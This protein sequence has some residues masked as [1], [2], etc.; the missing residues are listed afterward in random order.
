MN[1][2]Y[3]I[4]KVLYY[5]FAKLK[6]LILQSLTDHLGKTSSARISSYFILAQIILSSFVF[7]TIDVVNALLMWKKNEVFSVS[8]EHIVVFG[9]IL[10]HHLFLLGL[11]KAT[12]ETAFPTLDTKIK[13]AQPVEYELIEEEYEEEY[14]EEEE[15]PAPRKVKRRRK[16]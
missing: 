15:V 3:S 9:M 5:M 4:N 2:I 13:A 6:T 12:E 10:T 16:K 14:L 1:L 8:T 11:K 7:I